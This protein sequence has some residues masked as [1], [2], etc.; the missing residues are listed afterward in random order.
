MKHDYL[1]GRA[2]CQSVIAITVFITFSFKATVAAE[3]EQHAGNGFYSPP[4]RTPVENN[5][6]WGDLHVHSNLSADAYINGVRNISQSDAY[7]FAQ[8]EKIVS[9][10]G[11]VAKLLRPLDFLAVTD[12]AEN[13]GLYTRIDAKDPLIVNTVAGIRYSE[14]LGLFEKFGLRDAFTQVIKKHGPMPDMPVKLK[15][16]VWQDV[17]ETAD[18][19]N[20]PGRF[21]ALIG[22]EWTSMINGDNLHRVVLYRD[23]AEKAVK[24]L[25]ISAVEN[26][27]PEVLWEGLEKYE[28]MT[29]GS[30]LAIPHNGNLSN[31]RMFAPAT[32]AGKT[33]DQHYAETRM[34][35]EPVYEVTQI[36]GDG[37]AH[38]KLS[39]TDEF[40]NFET[41]D[42]TN[43]AFTAAKEPWMLQYEYAR[44]ALLEGLKHEKN[45]GANP[46]KFGMIGST[47]SHTALSTVREDNF[48]GKF[49]GSNP[50]SNRSAEKMGGQLQSNQDL[51]AS[52]L[53]AV[54]ARENSREALF[55]AIK[56]REVY[57]TTGNRIRLRFFGGWNYS[58]QDIHRADYVR[59]GY[60]Q[61][62]PMGSDLPPVK[63]SVSRKQAPTFLI[64][65][66]RDPDAA[67]LDR[68]QVVKGWIDES[69][70]TH[71]KIYNV[72]L[73]NA[74][75]RFR[76]GKVLPVA[77][78][79]EVETARYSNRAG[80]PELATWWR[81]PDFNPTHSTFYYVRV[82]EV[83]TPRWTT[84][85]AAFYDLPLSLSV[86]PTIQDR[87]Y[88]SPIWY[89]P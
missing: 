51:G 8:G 87:A 5:L 77:D 80:E 74:N 1:C 25:P 84:Y 82:L 26:P 38:P 4:L 33:I 29:G 67:F 58:E 46:F 7:R 64:H 44:S 22:Y 66:A 56:R 37:E 21:T 81:D 20:R 14:V 73:A 27:D 24:T 48:F 12:H 35:W 61:G 3:P 19:Y 68:V 49:T 71:E 15:R 76:S 65:A 18:A 55:D 83:P 60:R 57:A 45:V 30:I 31:G 17:V 43:V 32:V 72:A 23:G 88:S 75:A 2:L 63:K 62:V 59:H 54:W 16:S 40:A 34:R 13:I 6:Y 52:G 11:V 89:T 79:V 41:W 86:P 47:D 39:P 36:K 28:E 50:S 42:K 69:G 53:T 9:G 85:D 70:N 10:N 78:T